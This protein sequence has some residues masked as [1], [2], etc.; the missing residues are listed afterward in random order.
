MSSQSSAGFILPDGLYRE[1][2]PVE[3]ANEE[4]RVGRIDFVAQTRL[5]FS[6]DLPD[7]GRDLSLQLDDRRLFV[8]RQEFQVVHRADVPL[9][10]T[11]GFRDERLN[12]LSEFFLRSLIS[13][14]Q[15]LD[16]GDELIE[17][18]GQQRQKQVVLGGKIVVQHRFRRA[19][20]LGDVIQLG[21]GISDLGE[22]YRRAVENRLIFVFVVVCAYPRHCVVP[23]CVLS[24]S[25]RSLDRSLSKAKPEC[26]PAPY[27]SRH[28]RKS[29]I[30]L[31]YVPP[32]PQ[33]RASTLDEDQL[34][35]LIFDI[36]ARELPPLRA[37]SGGAI[38]RN[39]AW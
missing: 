34:V 16:V 39:S 17:M 21:A 11:G 12:K 32:R 18:L 19:A 5:H 26:R 36:A 33:T 25:A 2:R 13:R 30:R 3:H 7:Q 28:F 31:Y 35:G 20:E 37:N 15:F 8:R 29:T 27:R 4:H 23:V 22:K 38:E 24:P 14:K 1:I 6:Q 10:R 9:P